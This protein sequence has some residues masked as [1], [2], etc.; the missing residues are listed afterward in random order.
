M[1]SSNNMLAYNCLCI[2]DLGSNSID[3]SN[4]LKLIRLKCE[5]TV[6]LYMLKYVARSFLSIIT[7]SVI[8]VILKKYQLWWIH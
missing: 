4:Q 6:L 3:V 2:L 1:S 8:A 5:A 7:C